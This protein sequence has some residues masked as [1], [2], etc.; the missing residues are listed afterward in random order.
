MTEAARWEFACVLA[1]VPP[2]AMHVAWVDQLAI[3]I[4]NH[5]GAL[6][7]LEDRCSHEDFELS[8]GAFD[9]ATGSVECVLHGAKFDVCTG[10]ALCAPAYTPVRKFP[11]RVEG[12]VVYVRVD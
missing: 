11:L 3:L 8:Q 9:P 6:Y 10:A 7:A 2:G 1:E 5:D 12:E 4:V